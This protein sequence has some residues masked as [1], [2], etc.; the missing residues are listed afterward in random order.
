MVLLG[1]VKY[2]YRDVISS[3]SAAECQ[4][5]QGRWESFDIQGLNVPK[6]QPRNLVH[7]AN[8]LVGKDFQIVLQGAP[9]VLFD[10]I[11]DDLRHCWTTLAHLSSYAFQNEIL[12]K[13]KHISELKVVAARFL[14]QLIRLTAQWSNKPKFHMLTHLALSVERFGPAPLYATQKMESYNGVTRIASVHSNRHSPRRDIANTA[15]NERLLRMLL[16]GASFYDPKI[17]GRAQ[18]ST[19]VRDIFKNPIIQKGFGWNHV[20]YQAADASVTG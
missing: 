8:S 18:A 19:R 16:S 11:S 9:F 6:V 12:D 2:L 17:H 1:V 14:C 7:H 3:L 15:N 20:C 4:E 10:F 13:T 5:V